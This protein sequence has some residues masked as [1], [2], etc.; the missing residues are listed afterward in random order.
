MSLVVDETL[1]QI[2]EF[3]QL[4]VPLREELLA[5]IVMLGQIPAPTGGES[6]RAQF[7]L[8]RFVESGVDE[9]SAD[10]AGNA[11]GM[12]YGR[13][14]QRTIMLV[15][16]LDTIVPA[17]VDHNVVVHSDSIVGPC[18]GDNALGAAVLTLLPDVLSDLGI[19]LDSH[20]VMVGTVRSLGRGNHEGIRYQ[21]DHLDRPVDCGICIEGIQLGRLNYFS[22]GTIRGDITCT[23]RPEPSRSYGSESALIV[24]NHI[25][26]RVLRIA[27]PKRPYTLIR[28]GKMKAGISHDT[29]PDQAEL[30]FE[31]ISHSDE[32]IEQVRREIEDIVGEMSARHAVDAKLDVFFSRQAG[33]ISF[34]H[35]LVRCVLE[36]MS[37]LDIPPDQGHSPSELSEFISRGIPAVT[38]G[39]THGEKNTKVPDYVE[40]GPML[41]GVAQLAGVLV[42]IDQGVCDES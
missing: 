27:T 4:L 21:L 14:G 12:K 22:I 31:V 37:A 10:D 5:N 18:V 11:V 34:S 42:A 24:L 30:G 6:D 3:P 29:D 35:P 17:T 40:I 41:S 13:T 23:V 1:G 33:G 15:A 2:R 20:L 26:N 25:I 16:H 28:L 39:I 36:V 38:L 7:V 32:M 19:E 8:D 9:V